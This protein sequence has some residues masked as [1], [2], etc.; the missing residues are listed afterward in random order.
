MA[1]FPTESCGFACREFEGQAHLQPPA[2]T[3]ANS[4]NAGRMYD[5]APG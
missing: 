3:G 1:L 2:F 5:E 4:A